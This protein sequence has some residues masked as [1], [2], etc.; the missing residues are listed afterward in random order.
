MFDDLT[1]PTTN[2][3]ESL[4]TVEPGPALADALKSIDR[5]TLSPAEKVSVMIAHRRLAAHYM[6]ESYTDIA[7]LARDMTTRTDLADLVE[8]TASEVGAAL[9]LTRRSAER[10]TDLALGMCRR[11]PAVHRSLLSG[12][13][14]SVRARVLVE[15]TEHLD[16]TDA[17]DVIDGIIREAATMTAG[18]IAA[19]L[20]RVC[21]AADPAAAEKRYRHA[22]TRRKVFAMPTPDGAADLLGLSL[23]TERVAVISE[24]LDR[25]ARGLL[26]GGETRTMDQLRADIFLDLLEG[27]STAPKTGGG[28]HLHVDLATLIELDDTPGEIGGFGPVV[29]DLARQIAGGQL[30]STWTFT[31]TDPDDGTVLATGTTRR[32]PT[33]AQRRAIRSRYRHCVWPGC[34][35]PS[36]NCDIDHRTPHADGGPTHPHNLAPLCRHHHRIRHLAMWTYRRLPDG[37]HE[38]TTATGRTVLSPARSP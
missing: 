23:P 2:S 14:D 17:R 18:Q 35:M 8:T 38:W 37:D 26:G 36:M 4:E 22:V 29:A 16:D 31:I 3:L 1:T 20:R 32:R 11:L 5:S 10:E 19:R 21:L 24:R 30:H 33:T 6:A 13:I 7:A 28:V 34:R 12:D 15:G 9:W 25:M 27:K